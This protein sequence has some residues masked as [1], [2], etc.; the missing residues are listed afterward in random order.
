MK[1]LRLA[2]MCCA[3]SGSGVVGEAFAADGDPVGIY[4]PDVASPP[5]ARAVA[6]RKVVEKYSDGKPRVE[7]EAIQ[8]SDEQFINHG[9][10]VEYYAN[11]N[12]YAEGTYKQGVYDG[13]WKFWYENGQL[14]KEVK[15]A[16]GVPDG[17][18]ETRRAD[19]TLR[20]VKAY[21]MGRRE[22]RW[23][24]Y[25]DDGTTVKVEQVYADGGLNGERIVYFPSGKPKQKATLKNGVLDGEIT[26]WDEAGRKVA[27]FTLVDGKIHG[28]LR[29]WDAQGKETA[30]EFDMGKRVSSTV[31]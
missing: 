26:E 1:C 17:Q 5:A 24:D 25:N 18:W 22:G 8:M 3:L 2:L 20:S 9:S 23:I 27:Q 30:L 4:L 28:V 13:V 12:K 31:N 10:Y 11:G 15:F 14:C 16:E 21:K 7:R 6:P 29:R 19:G